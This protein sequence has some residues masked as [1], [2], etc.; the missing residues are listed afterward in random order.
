VNSYFRSYSGK[1]VHPL[2]PAPEEID[3]DDI[4][5]SSVSKDRFLRRFRELTK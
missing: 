3:I 1:H 4:A 2:S 5:H